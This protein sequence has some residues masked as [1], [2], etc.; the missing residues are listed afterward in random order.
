MEYRLKARG[1]ELSIIDERPYD[2]DIGQPVG[3][4]IY[5]DGVTCL[6]ADGDRSKSSAHE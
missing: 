3:V 5:E 6:P 4:R 1:F 2:M